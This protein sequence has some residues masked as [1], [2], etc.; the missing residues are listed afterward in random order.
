MVKVVQIQTGLPVS[1]NMPYKLHEAFLRVGID[2]KFVV[3]DSKIKNSLVKEISSLPKRIH[4]IVYNKYHSWLRNKIKP[5]SY[6]FSNPIYWG[7]DISGFQFV[8]DADIIYLHWVVGGFLSIGTIEKLLQTQKPLVVFL[9]D[10]WPITGGCHHSFDCDNYK[11]GCHSCPM[12]KSDDG[13]SVAIN[14]LKKKMMLA[15]IHLNLYFIAPSKW[16]F[17]CAIH[18]LA[19]KKENVLLVP[20]LYSGKVFYKKS[21]QKCLNKFSLPANKIIIGFGSLNAISNPFKGLKFLIEAIYQL[22]EFYNQEEIILVIFGASGQEERLSLPFQSV[23]LE[24]IIDQNSLADLYNCFNVFVTP[25]LA[26]SFGMTALESI[27]CGTPVA[28]FDVGG[29]RDVV[30]HKKTG[31][32]SIY[33]DS[34]DLAHGIKFCIDQLPEVVVSNN[35]SE[36]NVVNKH[37]QIFNSIL[38]LQAKT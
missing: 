33:K 30:Q 17:D 7:I 36:T 19:T 38:K 13:R 12:F 9:H 29:L 20:H 32:K 15:Q 6:L 24:R 1:G 3:F 28:C 34:I 5:G 25:S 37:V 18:S 31:Y 16:L 2:S 14:Q 23:W 21:R 4:A 11:S 27:A 22:K 10:M 35:F 26:E 8:K